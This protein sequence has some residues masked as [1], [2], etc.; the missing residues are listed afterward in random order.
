MIAPGVCRHCAC[1]EEQPCRTHDGD[2]CCWVDRKRIVC[3]APGC[4]HAEALRVASARAQ[5]PSAKYRG[6][7]FGAIIDDKRRQERRERRKKGRAA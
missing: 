7:G 4:L 1:T 2:T 5:R 6:W 3:T